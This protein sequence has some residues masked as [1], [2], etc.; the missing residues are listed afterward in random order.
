MTLD[1]KKKRFLIFSPYGLWNVHNQLEAVVGSALQ[2]RGSEVIVIGCDGLFQSE[3]YILRTNQNKQDGCSS[4][5]HSHKNLFSAFHLAQR[6]L[7]EF[8]TPEDFTEQ[9]QLLASKP[10]D[11][12]AD[13]TYDGISLGQI[14]RPA[15]CS[16]LRI[17][18]SYFHHPRSQEMLRR[19]SAD[20]LLCTRG[21]RRALDEYKPDHV[22]EFNGNGFLHGTV[23]HEARKRDIPI[24]LHEKATIDGTFI[25]YDSTTLADIRPLT[26]FIK[27]WSTTPLCEPE[28]V[29]VSNS[30]IAREKGEGLNLPGFYEYSSDATKARTQLRLQPDQ[31]IFSA[32]TSSEY[33]LVYW[34]EYLTMS[35]QLD[36]LDRLIEI[37]KDRRETLV[38]RH[39][40]NVAGGPN[41]PPD[42][43][44]L[45]RLWNQ[46]KHVH[47]NVRIIMPNEKLT[48]YALL[49]LT[50]ACLS[51][52]STVTVEAL[53]RGIPAACHKNYMY[54]DSLP[55]S[56][57]SVDPKELN[58]LIDSLLS[59]R[60]DISDLKKLFRMYHS[61][62]FR[63][64][65]TFRSFS[66]RN[67]SEMDIKITDLRQLLPGQ[68]QALDLICEHLLQGGPLWPEP[69][70]NEPSDN[71][72]NRDNNNNNDN[73]DNNSVEQNYL[74]TYH[75]QLLKNHTQVKNAAASANAKAPSL[76]LDT[77][78]LVIAAQFEGFATP[79]S[80][81][82]P[83]QR[84]QVN[85]FINWQVGKDWTKNLSAA[86]LAI[87]TSHAELVS[88]S[89]PGQ[90]CSTSF[91]SSAVDF[92][93]ERPG[94]GGVAFEHWLE[95]DEHLTATV[96]HDQLWS[97]ARTDPQVLGGLLPVSGMVF[98][99]SVASQL[100]VQ[101]MAA[102]DSASRLAL[103]AKLLSPERIYQLK[104]VAVSIMDFESLPRST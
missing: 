77:R 33:E 74:S 37:F 55:F 11:G 49:P 7:R 62:F 71:R 79:A 102:H 31:R 53:A 8:L 27:Q 52:F 80:V 18:P 58:T 32:F 48:S 82:W 97:R 25:L 47:S 10:K 89:F 84:H 21:I 92:L 101:L 54:A 2:L 103:V 17:T 72:D 16:Y 12:W 88:F 60:V 26:K 6:Q 57:D 29:Q 83:Q 35:E 99:R 68:D 46:A 93:A 9:E 36:L 50:S 86:L 98:S 95:V 70:A 67:K 43:S 28:L 96:T 78:V 38:I 73:N 14:V 4:C 66:V 90:W 42:Y 87:D 81:W 15:V 64:P 75:E 61:L 104:D 30:L 59:H 1:S 91:I 63:M 65:A 5:A 94:Y 23:F 100:L 3:C 56:F 20:A 39:H 41:S 24:L 76:A 44:F 40:P 22:I 13:V 69:E 51:N 34:D 19:Y 85:G 45:T